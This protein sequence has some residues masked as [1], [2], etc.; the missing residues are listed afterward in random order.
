MNTPR[1]PILQ[2]RR[3][4]WAIVPVK[5]L[6]IGKQ[7]LAR[8]LSG[9]ERAAMMRG[10][11]TRMLSVLRDVPAI[12]RVLVISSDAAVLDLA[13]RMGAV[14]CDEGAMTGLNPAVTRAAQIAAAAQATAVLILPADLPCIQ[15]SDVEMMCR[16]GDS[17][18]ICSDGQGEGTNALLIPLPTRFQ[19]C[20]GPGSFRQHLQEAKRV[21]LAARVIHAPGLKF[22]MDTEEDWRQ[23]QLTMKNGQ[24]RPGL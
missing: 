17:V 8:V 18:A 9:D 5:P 19:P 7:R 1:S 24:L 3:S 13:A 12:D 15:A 23:Y 10:F 11:L 4:L 22:D 14:A 21:G 16:G 2:P 6:H 20:Y